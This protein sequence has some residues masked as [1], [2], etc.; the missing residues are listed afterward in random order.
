MD[1]GKKF[2]ITQFILCMYCHVINNYHPF[3]HE[4]YSTYFFGTSFVG[5]SSTDRLSYFWIAIAGSIYGFSLFI[6]K[7]YFS[8][9]GGGLGSTACITVIVV[10]L[11]NRLTGLL[12]KEQNKSSVQ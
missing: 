1:H 3:E 8:G 9:I 5:M 11:M 10:F 12:T 2:S 7:D 4:L 6:F